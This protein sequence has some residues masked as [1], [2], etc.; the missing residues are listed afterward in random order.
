MASQVL[1]ESGGTVS[2][3]AGAAVGASVV[4]P[5]GLALG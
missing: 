4:E 1:H 5:V 2:S 3:V